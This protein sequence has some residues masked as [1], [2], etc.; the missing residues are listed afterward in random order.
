MPRV[1][2]IRQKRRGV[3]VGSR[4]ERTR[5][6]SV[7]PAGN[8]EDASRLTVDGKNAG[9]RVSGGDRRF[10]Y[11]P[12]AATIRRMK[13]AR[14]VR[15]AR[16]KINIFVVHAERAVARRESPFIRQRGRHV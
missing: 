13:N 6:V 5:Y 11:T 14:F 2:A 15:A 16:C 4:V 8:V 7:I 1:V 12:C 10:D 9:G 3:E